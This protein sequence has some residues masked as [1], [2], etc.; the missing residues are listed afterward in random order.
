MHKVDECWNKTFLIP[1]G[2]F[3]KTMF[4][5]NHFRWKPFSTKNHFRSKPFSIKTIFEEK[6]FSIKTIFE[7]KLVLTIMTVPHKARS[8]VDA[9]LWWQEFLQ[10]YNDIQ[11]LNKEKKKKIINKE[12]ISN[13]FI[14]HYYQ[15][16]K[17]KLEIVLHLMYV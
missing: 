16:T 5:L 7:E 10:S 2:F 15:R 17:D 14:N 1:T 9:Q 6:P 13:C 11:T 8:L 12:K 3:I 4:D